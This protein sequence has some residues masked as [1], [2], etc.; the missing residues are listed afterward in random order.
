M[1]KNFKVAQLVSIL[2]IILGLYLII[3][4]KIKKNIEI[5]NDNNTTRKAEE[6]E[7]Y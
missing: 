6:E 5:Y 2:L 3:R 1:I 7:V 4:P